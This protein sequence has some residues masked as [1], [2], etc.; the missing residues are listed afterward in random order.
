L[1]A[2]PDAP[3]LGCAILAAYGA[4]RVAS[5]EEG[6]RSMVHIAHTVEP[7]DANAKRYDSLCPQYRELYAALKQVRETS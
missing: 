6:S 7:N 1:T 4:G 2:V 3:A 5:I